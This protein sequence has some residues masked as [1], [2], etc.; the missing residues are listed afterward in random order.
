VGV[1]PRYII[2][3]DLHVKIISKYKASC[4]GVTLS[5]V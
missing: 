2:A 5:S 1:T 4:N 3:V